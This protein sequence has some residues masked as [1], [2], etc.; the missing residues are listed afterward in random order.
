MGER[1]EPTGDHDA[2]GAGALVEQTTIIPP[3]L[4]GAIELDVGFIFGDLKVDPGRLTVAVTV[5]LGENVQCR[6]AFAIGIQPTWRLRD[7]E[8]AEDDET[9]EEELEPDGK[10][11]RGVALEVQSTT[12][13]T[14]GKNGTNQP[15]G[16]AK[17]GDDTTIAGVSSL[18]NPDGACCCSDADTEA[19]QETATHEL[20]LGGVGRGETLDNGA[21]DNADRADQHTPTAAPCV[22]GR[23]GEW[24]GADT[25][26]L[27]HRRDETSPDTLVLA[28][29]V[30][31]EVLLIVEQTT[32]QHAVVAVHGLAEEA[33]HE[34]AEE[35]QLTGRSPGDGFLEQGLIVGLATLDL[36]D[37]DDL[38]LSVAALEYG[39]CSYIFDA[40]NRV[41]ALDRGIG[42]L[43]N[44][45]H[46]DC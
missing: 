22:D 27:M 37:V 29:E 4:V 1:R 23:T 15:G 33:N 20:A 14:G 21:D 18:D 16:V 38:D 24:K 6:L 10:Q 8:S 2:V 5:P 19:N 45:R 40:V 41:D 25:T 13:C 17:T 43:L 34:S 9:G 42:D 28:V 26:D 35:H 30:S 46:V 44:V 32:E 39:E 3:A 31:K 11:P 12:S 36:D 7:E